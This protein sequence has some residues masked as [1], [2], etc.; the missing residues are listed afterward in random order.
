MRPPDKLFSWYNFKLCNLYILYYI[1]LY[2][3]FPDIFAK[4]ASK[5]TSKK[6]DEKNNQQQKASTTDIFDDDSPSIFDDPLNA[7]G[8]K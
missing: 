5:K 3:Y 1:F 4:P 2:H 7:I 8:G 6:K